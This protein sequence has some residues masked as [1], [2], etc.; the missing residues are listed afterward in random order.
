MRFT[1]VTP[2]LNGMPW[3]PESIASVARQRPSVDLQH[4]VLDGG[5][6]D[7][8]RDWLSS[9]QD[10]GYELHLEPDDGQTDALIKG[11]ARAT[12]EL[13]GWL[14]ADDVI[15][16]GTLHRVHDLFESNPDVVMISGACLFIDQTGRVEGA[17]AVPGDPTF[18]GLLSVR[19]NPPQPSTFF[20]AD[21]YRRA[22]GLDRGFDLAMDVDLWL[23]LA[24]QGRY[25][26]LSNEILARYRV[27]GGA[28][29]ERMATASAREDLRARRNQGMR[30]RSLAGYQLLRAAYV[31]PVMQPIRRAAKRPL[32]RL[33]GGRP[34]SA[35]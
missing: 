25:M 9:H 2:V 5:S 27:H 33:V 3:L 21:A 17:M 11:F 31:D 14:N 28:K 23:R 6:T 16:P 15:E 26:V 34:S 8:S 7:G 20:R 35:K 1:I 12:G 18:Q 19:E 13:C 10:L 32:K 22:G 29:S 24:Q 30:W 4:I